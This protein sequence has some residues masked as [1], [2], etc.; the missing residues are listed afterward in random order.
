M[1]CFMVK[2]S[3][4]GHQNHKMGVELMEAL[5][6]RLRQRRRQMRLHQRDVAG[7]NSASF[8]SKVETGV[9][10]P[11]L[12]NLTEWSVALHTTIGDLLGDQLLLEAAKQTILLTD[13]CH[14]YLDNLADTMITKF[15]RELSTSASSV[16]TP[17]PRPPQDPEL[18]YLT[19]RVLIHRGL[20]Q[21]AKGLVSTTLALTLDP[22]W[23]IYHLSL[24]CQIHEELSED[25]QKREIKDELQSLLSSLDYHTLLHALPEGESL[26]LADLELLKLSQGLSALCP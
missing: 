18:Q 7:K 13:R 2:F 21:E 23:R 16:S 26:T 25:L 17:V 15:L 20:I 12:K 24:L 19:A 5:G 4:G 22:L 1:P 6:S 10:Y 11:S 3:I 8:L 14:S 9:A